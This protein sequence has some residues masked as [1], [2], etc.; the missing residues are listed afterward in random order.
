MGLGLG[1]GA[2]C[3]RCRRAHQ[4]RM[5]GTLGSSGP[6]GQVRSCRA[7]YLRRRSRRSHCPGKSSRVTHRRRPTKLPRWQELAVYSSFVVL[8]VSGVVWL[9]LDRWVRIAGEF[10]PEHH[11]AE[12]VSLILHAIGAYAFLVILGE[13]GRAHV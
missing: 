9:I 10:G 8:L 6:A 12:H 1:A 13:I 11:P 7:R 4:A 2:E 3:V 5:G